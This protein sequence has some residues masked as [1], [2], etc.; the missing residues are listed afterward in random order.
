MDRGV[1]LMKV[2]YKEKKRVKFRISFIFLFIIASFAICFVMYMNGNSD[3]DDKFSFEFLDKLKKNDKID[4]EDA[5]AEVDAVSIKQIVN[6]IKRSEPAQKS[7]Y[8]DTLFIGG[9]EIKGLVDYGFIPVNNLIYDDSLSVISYENCMITY[10]DNQTDILSVIND[11]APKAVYFHLGMN[12]LTEISNQNYFNEYGKLFDKIR[13]G[14][15]DIIIYVM[16]LMPITADCEKDTL[17]NALI[18]TYNTELLGFAKEKNICYID[19]N[20]QFKGND[21]K[22]P[23]A[24]AE[25]HSTR[26]KK[27]AYEELSNYILTHVYNGE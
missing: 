23:S 5:I 4:T 26:L 6:P 16:S 7:Y 21:G 9:F 22:L 1:S 11:T 13:Q 20:T 17:S 27:D 24:M 12:E 18:D 10:K 19:I 25:S 8:S 3:I 14:N 2:H 15:D